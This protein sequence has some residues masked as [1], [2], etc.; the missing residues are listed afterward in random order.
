MSKKRRV[1]GGGS[2]YHARMHVR[3]RTRARASGLAALVVLSVVGLAAPASAQSIE[4]GETDC[5][6]PRRAMLTWLANLQPSDPRPA[7]AARC[8]DWHGARL[9]V[10]GHARRAQGLKEVLD[11]R[12]LWVS[13]EDIPDEATLESGDRYAPFP[14]SFPI[15]SLQRHGTEWLVSAD[16]VRAIPE[17]QR[18]TFPLDVDSWLEAGPAFLR[19]RVF[20]VAWWQIVGAVVLVGLGLLVRKLIAWLVASQGGHLLSLNK[21]KV[22]ATLVSAAASPVG[23]LAAV[24]LWTWALPVLRFEVAMNAASFFALRVAAAVTGVLTVYRVVDVVSDVWRLHAAATETKLDDQLV[25]LVRKSAKVVTVLV[26]LIFVLQ[27]LEVD[28]ASLIAGASLGGLAFSLAARDTV[29]NLFG[30][31]SIFTDRPFQVGDWVK[32]EGVEG[33][34]EEVGIRSTRIRTF[35]RSL[36]TVP[37]SKVADAVVDNYGARDSRRD[38]FRL[39]VTYAT[40]SEQMEALCDGIRAILA[41]NPK[42]K[43]DAY[44]VHFAAFADSGLEILLYYFLVVDS[45]S[46]ELRQRHLLYLEIMRLAEALGVEFAFPTRTL[47]IASQASPTPMGPRPAPS[48]AVLGERV[49]L[50]ASGGERSR[51]AGPHITD[52]YYPNAAK[53]GPEPDE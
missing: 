24:M 44:E 48:D 30:S 25:P 16:T 22:D 33:I 52:G 13:M 43:K 1:R 35:Y 49:R 47:H 12:G 10:A 26:G 36:V 18:Q 15:L 8:F 31:L 9:D 40:T 17:L 50:F 29:A 20:G 46:D 37:N 23:T 3:T 42:V 27:N 41:A 7:A 32:V 5:S 28:V 21:M 4:P 45:W 2:R 34:V 19:S 51:P 14:N 11:A 6:T 53:A 38:T 39:G